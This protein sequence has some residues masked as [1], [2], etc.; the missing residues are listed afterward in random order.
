MLHDTCDSLSNNLRLELRTDFFLRIYPRTHKAGKSYASCLEGS[1]MT[2]LGGCES[3]LFLRCATESL[4]ELCRRRPLS[5]PEG[6]AE[7]RTY[8]EVAVLGSRV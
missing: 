5:L 3:V 6:I 4:I 1:Y 8:R 2:L 7:N